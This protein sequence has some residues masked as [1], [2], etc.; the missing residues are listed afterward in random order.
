MEEAIVQSLHE[1][2][3]TVIGYKDPYQGTPLIKMSGNS[4]IY[5]ATNYRVL[6]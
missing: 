5:V 2:N 6:Y 4:I 3:N 1:N